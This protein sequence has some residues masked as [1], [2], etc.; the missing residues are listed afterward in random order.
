MSLRKIKEQLPNTVP[1]KDQLPDLFSAKSQQIHMTNIYTTRNK[2]EL[3]SFSRNKTIFLQELL[4]ALF[5]L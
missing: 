5:S 1:Y 3:E 2:R 4:A